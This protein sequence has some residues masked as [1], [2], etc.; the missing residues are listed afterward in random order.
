MQNKDQKTWQ[1]HELF[2]YLKDKKKEHKKVTEQEL[3]NSVNTQAEILETWGHKNEMKLAEDKKNVTLY[4]YINTKKTVWEAVAQTERKLLK[5][6]TEKGN[7]GL[8][9]LL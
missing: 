8:F 2:I 9:F 6:D 7:T 1:H 3:K 5:N 4:M